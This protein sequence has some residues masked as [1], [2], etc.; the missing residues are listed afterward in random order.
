MKKPKKISEYPDAFYPW[1]D[2]PGMSARIGTALQ[3]RFTTWEQLGALTLDELIHI[4]GLGPSGI[5][6]VSAELVRRGLWKEAF[7]PPAKDRTMERL[8]EIER[9]ARNLVAVPTY[10]LERVVSAAFVKCLAELK[11]ALADEPPF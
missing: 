5:H 6:I 2:K 7:P 11:K 1:T 10:S 8:L 3:S 4:D 9:L